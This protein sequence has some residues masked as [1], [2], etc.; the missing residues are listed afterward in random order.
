MAETDVADEGGIK[1]K[2]IEVSKNIKIKNVDVGEIKITVNPKDIFNEVVSLDSYKGKDF[3]KDDGLKYEVNDDFFDQASMIQYNKEIYT[4][5][6]LIAYIQTD[7]V[8]VHR[9]ELLT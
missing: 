2:N 7:P 1:T 5:V 8:T 4:N 9:Q 6:T 3:Y